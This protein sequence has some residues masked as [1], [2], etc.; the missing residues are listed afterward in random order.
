MPQI[1]MIVDP[2]V[3][4]GVSDKLA[5]LGSALIE[6][7]ERVFGLEGKNDVASTTIGALS[8]VNEAQ[9]QIEVRYTV[10]QDEYGRG[11]PFEPSREKRE[12]LASKLMAV[13]GAYLGGIVYRISVWVK[14]QRDTVFLMKLP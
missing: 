7:T 8:T 3:K 14:P 2:S 6:T 12:E 11:E 13:A 5:G 4:K 10:G 9:L 1:F